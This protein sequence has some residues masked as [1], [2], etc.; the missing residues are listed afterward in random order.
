[1]NPSVPGPLPLDK[2]YLSA[3]LCSGQ[4]FPDPDGGNSLNGNGAKIACGF[5]YFSG[6]VYFVLAG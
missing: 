3:V 1:M 4:K 6:E 2:V 5:R